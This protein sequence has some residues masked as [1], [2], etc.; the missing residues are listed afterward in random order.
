MQFQD[1]TKV[2]FVLNLG[3][4]ANLTV[5]DCQGKIL[6]A[7][8]VGPANT[9]L[10]TVCRMIFNKNYDK[11]GE[12]SK[13]GQ[14]NSKLLSDY[15]S[16]D[17]LQLPPPKSTGRETFNADFIKEELLIATTHPEFAYDLMA[18]LAEFT[19][20]SCVNAVRGAIFK[21]KIDK[22]RLI[23]CGGG[24]YNPVIMSKLSE[25]LAK[26]NVET[27]IADE[28][29]VNSKLIEAHAFAYFA[30]KFVKREPLDLACSTNARENS[31]L[32]CLYPKTPL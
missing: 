25:A 31:I 20:L 3:G 28:L 29:G 13:K 10:D 15:M 6:Q 7:Y 30:Y 16:C 11:D 21:F 4:I 8:D 12:L 22:S 9:L 1:P 19:A 14:V 5:I 26:N 23:I 2:S 32:G 24:A 27:Y 18:T 17:Y